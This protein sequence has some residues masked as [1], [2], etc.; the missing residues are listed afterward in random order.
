[1]T[2]STRALGSRPVLP[3]QVAHERLKHGQLPEDA[4][5]DRRAAVGSIWNPDGGRLIEHLTRAARPLPGGRDGAL[6]A[7]LIQ[8][9]LANVSAVG[10]E[11]AEGLCRALEQLREDLGGN[12]PLHDVIATF[13]EKTPAVLAVLQD[14]AARAD[15]DAMR[16]AAHMIKGTSAML[17]GRSPSN[18]QHSKSSVEAASC[19]TPPAESDGNRSDVPEHRGR[20]HRGR[21]RYD[22][23]DERPRLT[24]TINP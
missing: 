20:A 8:N 3:H 14:A 2:V 23:A 7:R 10:M 24:F 16:R 18:A 13:L 11:G 17:G 15:A 21:R 12:A 1:M 4:L 6:G 19:R 9:A 22:P 5:V